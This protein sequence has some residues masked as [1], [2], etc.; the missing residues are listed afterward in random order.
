M[1]GNA[2]SGVQLVW[3][4][5]VL[6]KRGPDNWGCT[7]VYSCSLGHSELHVWIGA[8]WKVKGG[9]RACNNRNILDITNLKWQSTADLLLNILATS[10]I[11]S[12]TY[13]RWA[14]PHTKHLTSQ[15]TTAGSCKKSLKCTR[16]ET[17]SQTVEIPIKLYC[18][19]MS[20][21]TYASSTV[22][23]WDKHKC[24]ISNEARVSRY[25]LTFGQIQSP[26]GS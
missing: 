22:K 11:S 26:T 19:A 17:T 23:C 10:R 12:S 4:I 14:C 24:F 21:P 15:S 16:V 8:Y 9:K 18:M 20:T 7:A 3:I 5:K 2:F 6:D 13:T 1:H 25:L